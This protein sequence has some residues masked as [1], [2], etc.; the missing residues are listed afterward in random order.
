M[1][2]FSWFSDVESGHLLFLQLVLTFQIALHS[3]ML[4][5]QFHFA[6]VFTGGNLEKVF[7]H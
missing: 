4:A 5:S 3:V 7:I 1:P 2:L 6:V